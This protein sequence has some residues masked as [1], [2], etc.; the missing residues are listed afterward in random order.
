MTIAS[1]SPKERVMKAICH[2]GIDR[3]P[4]GELIVD[5][6]FIDKLY[7]QMRGAS[8]TGKMRQFV[9]DVDLDLV[10]VL[11]DGEKGI[12][13][14]GYWAGQTNRFVMALVDGLFWKPEDPFSFQEFL[15]GISQEETELQE[16]IQIKKRRA[17]GLIQKSL[18]AGAHGIIIGDDLAYDRGPFISPKD[19]RKLFFP[20]LR[21]MVE[22]IGMG[23][24]VPFLHSC[25]NLHE[26]IDHIVSAGFHGIHGLA[27]SAGNDVMAIRRMT[28]RKLAIMGV[29]EVDS[30]KPGEIEALK[31]ETLEPLAEQGGYIL[32]SA[33]GLSKNTPV[34]SFKA[35]YS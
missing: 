12:G 20:G 35:L 16:L 21:E 32:G 30:M 10:T 8:S 34:E 15:L 14:V 6:A 31:R 7:P 3:L 22:V 19:L 13:E 2:E 33:G 29:I 5:E 9:E 17:L 24:G 27:P 1:I 4:R 25:G 18:D 28:N 26:I 11:M 23:D